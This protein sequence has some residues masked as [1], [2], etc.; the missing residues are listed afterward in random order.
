MTY[1]AEDGYALLSENAVGRIFR[2]TFAMSEVLEV[3]ETDEG[4][5]EDE[6]SL[7]ASE[8][9]LAVR[10]SGKELWTNEMVIA[11]EFLGNQLDLFQ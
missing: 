3:Q 4:E 6:E 5:K 8:R 2:V 9:L 10:A 11:Q 1:D 7:M